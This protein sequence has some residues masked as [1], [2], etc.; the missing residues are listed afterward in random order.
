MLFRSLAYLH[1]RG[2]GVKHQFGNF[3]VTELSEI[4]NFPQEKFYASGYS[5]KLNLY[6]SN[7]KFFPQEEKL[8]IFNH[9]YLNTN[10]DKEFLIRNINDITSGEWKKDLG[11]TLD[12]LT[13]NLEEKKSLILSFNNSILG[14][15]K[16]TINKVKEI[17][18]SDSHENKID[19]WKL[20]FEKR[21]KA[22][23]NNKG[24]SEIYH[25]LTQNFTKEEIK[26]NFIDLSPYIKDLFDAT[27]QLNVFSNTPKYSKKIKFEPMVI[28]KALKIPGFDKKKIAVEV[29]KSMNWIATILGY[30]YELFAGKKEVLVVLSSN[31][32]INAELYQETI[33]DYLLFIKNNNGK[34]LNETEFSKW[35]MQN[36]LDK[37]L[38]EK[39]INSSKIKI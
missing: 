11:K 7:D 37:K 33:K 21:K 29:P 20:F 3:Y 39:N 1:K 13:T 19:F 27:V 18:K 8:G 15:N 14:L 5:A 4:H 36:K 10:F 25:F 23:N 32:E 22:L 24:G 12:N 2:F 9:L 30:E 38:S 28:E 6:F 17:I 26:N 34:L 16:I 35:Y 31:H